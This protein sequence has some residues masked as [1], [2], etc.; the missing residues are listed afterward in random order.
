MGGETPPLYRPE[1]DVFYFL[2]TF[3][4]K[5]YDFPLEN[6]PTLYNKRTTF[7]HASQRN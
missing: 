1:I 4:G 3:I 6:F 2:S 7:D 5:H